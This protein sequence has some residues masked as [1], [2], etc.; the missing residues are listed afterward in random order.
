MVRAPKRAPHA[1]GDVTLASFFVK[2]K[3]ERGLKVFCMSWVTQ[4]SGY[5]AKVLQI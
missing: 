5:I 3:A 4:N 1:V 2:K